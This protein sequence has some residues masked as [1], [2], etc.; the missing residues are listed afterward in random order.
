M[1]LREDVSYCSACFQQQPGVTHVDFDAAWDGPVLADATG[2]PITHTIDE[3][4]ICENCME[5]AAK[6]LGYAKSDAPEKILKLEKALLEA[7]AGR[8]A[9]ENIVAE[10]RKALP[11]MEGPQTTQS[12]AA[13]QPVKRKP[14][15]PRKHPQPVEA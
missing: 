1:Q 9:A 12:A 2:E 3:L 4:A 11:P 14:G 15:R 6:L 8:R 5:A 10:F 7:N 13:P